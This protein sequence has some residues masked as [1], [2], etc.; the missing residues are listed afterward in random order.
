[1]EELRGRDETSMN[2]ETIM[3]ASEVASFLKVS[4]NAVRRWTRAGKLKG[5][6][7]G[8][9]GDWRYLKNDVMLFFYGNN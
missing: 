8:G 3:T 9:Q 1:M 6:R 7:L 5:H 4:V 2:I